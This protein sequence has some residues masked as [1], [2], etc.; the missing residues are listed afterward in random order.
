[1]TLFRT[2]KGHIRDTDWFGFHT[3]GGAT[4]FWNARVLCSRGLHV[5]VSIRLAA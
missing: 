5:Q 3:P 2:F 1:M 4:L